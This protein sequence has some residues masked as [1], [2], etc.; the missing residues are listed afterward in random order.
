MRLLARE[1]RQHNRV[2]QRGTSRTLLLNRDAV[3]KR[4]RDALRDSSWSALRSRS[5]EETHLGLGPNAHV[6][7]QDA[8]CVLLDA[9]VRERVLAEE[10]ARVKVRRKE[11]AV[12][13]ERGV[14]RE[15]AHVGRRHEVLEVC[16]RCQPVTEMEGEGRDEQVRKL[17]IVVLTL[18]SAS[19]SGV[20][21][22]R[23]VGW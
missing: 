1:S 8:L 5:K 7:L 15:A 22:S 9:E 18:T 13:L 10:R 3:S 6:A 19:A 17:S 14:G 12:A 11:A 23:S 2:G 20:S 4:Q 21:E 16:V